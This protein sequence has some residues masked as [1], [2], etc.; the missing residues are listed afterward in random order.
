[1]KLPPLLGGVSGAQSM[2]AWALAAVGAWAYYTYGRS[3]AP[4]SEN[5]KA[6]W[7]QKVKAKNPEVGK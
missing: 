1:M 2:A 7:N 5:E 4:F 3:V 6:Q